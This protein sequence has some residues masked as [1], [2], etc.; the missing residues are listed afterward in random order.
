VKA[1]DFDWDRFNQEKDAWEAR[2]IQS[3]RF[4][5]QSISYTYLG[6]PL[7]AAVTVTSGA[8]PEVEPWDI[9]DIFVVE[10]FGKTIDEIYSVIKARVKEVQLVPDSYLAFRIQ[11][12]EEYHYPASFSEGTDYGRFPAEV[13][14]GGGPVGFEITGFTVLP[15]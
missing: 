2:N 15:E 5:L 13:P 1:V 4:V 14:D 8:E 11:F 10:Q 6:R 3:Y 12:N 7:V 9:D